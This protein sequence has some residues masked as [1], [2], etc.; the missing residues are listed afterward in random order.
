VGFDQDNTERCVGVLASVLVLPTMQLHLSP[1]WILQLHRRIRHSP[2]LRLFGREVIS[3]HA[4]AT[5]A[6]VRAGGSI[7]DAVLSHPDQGAAQLIPQRSKKAVI[8]VL[9]IGDN[10]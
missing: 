9:G 1:A 10:E 8:A 3:V 5:A 2:S 4:G 6:T 7:Q